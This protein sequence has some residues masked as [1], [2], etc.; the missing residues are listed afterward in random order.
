[1]FNPIDT[2]RRWRSR[3]GKPIR[4]IIELQ[5]DG[6]IVN[7]ITN[8]IQTENMI[9]DTYHTE[10][11][12]VHPDDRTS[13][14]YIDGVY[15]GMCYFA[16]E[17]GQILKVKKDV[18]LYEPVLDENEKPVYNEDGTPKVRQVA[19]A[20][21]KGVFGLLLDASILEKG[22]ALKM[23]FTQTLIYV[24]LCSMTAFFMGMSYGH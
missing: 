7:I 12:E 3:L 17:E 23:P 14:M 20:A 15:K 1:M 11:W 2:I 19:L 18:E 9:M 24:V 16:C 10:A 21:W 13:A 8:T 5:K 22:S 4:P 6:S